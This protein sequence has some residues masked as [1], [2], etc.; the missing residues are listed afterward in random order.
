[1]RSMIIQISIF[2]LWPK[3]SVFSRSETEGEGRRSSGRVLSTSFQLPEMEVINQD[4]LTKKNIDIECFQA[5]RNPSFWVICVTLRF[6]K[7]LD[8]F[9]EYSW[10][11]WTSPFNNTNLII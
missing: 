2:T 7:L 11:H 5:E 1:M 10:E 4:E 6:W 3:F 9:L 8:Y